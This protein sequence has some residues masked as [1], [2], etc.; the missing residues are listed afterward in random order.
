MKKPIIGIAGN[1]YIETNPV[2]IGSPY[3][4]NNNNY[5]KCIADAGGIPIYLPV[6]NVPEI[7]DQQLDLID[8]LLIPGGNDINPLLYHQVP[9]PL[10]GHSNETVDMVQI[11]LIQ[12][13]LQ[14]NIP[15]LGICRGHQILNVAG[16]GTLHQDI[17][18]AIDDPIQHKQ[19]INL[20]TPTH[21]VQITPNS[22]LHSI[23]G[24]TYTVNSAHHQC[25]KD[26]APQFFATALSPD[27]IIEGIQM[28]GNSFVMG[29]QWHPEMMASRDLLML[30]LFKQFI[31]HCEAK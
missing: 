9:K 25:V 16:G 8:G 14:R 12:K 15:I 30:Q 6:I 24:P 2:V 19:T 31:T 3:D 20:A 13:A 22:I 10:Q 26:L 7:I 27:G 21:P 29:V 23:L 4:F 11:Y 17:S 18:Y 1:L 28:E 5:S